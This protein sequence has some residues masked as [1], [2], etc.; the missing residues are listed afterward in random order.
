MSTTVGSQYYAVDFHIH[1]PASS[2]YKDKHATPDDI[3]QAALTAGLAA[4]AITDH[5][6]PLG[7]DKVRKAA[8]GTGLVIFP[9]VE[10]TSQG[11]HIIAVFDP[12]ASIDAVE[13][14]LIECGIGKGQWEKDNASAIGKDIL[15]VLSVIASKGGLAIA[16]HADGPKGFFTTILQG[17]THIRIYKDP[18][19]AAVELIS[20]DKKDLYVEGKVPGYD[21][22]VPCIQGS[23]AHSL[24]Q[25]G[26]ACVL[27]R[28]H[29]LSLEGVRQA[30]ADPKM[31]IRFPG[32]WKS[33]KYPFV[34]GLRVNQGF[35]TG[36]DLKF[37]PN[38]NC[39][40]GGAGSGKSTVIE[41]IRFALDQVSGIEHIARDCLGKLRDLAQLGASIE[42]IVELESGER[43]SI[44]RTFN[45]DDSPTVVRRISD[46]QLLD[47]VDIR[48]IFPVHAYS[49][50]EVISIS[51]NP[52]AQLELIDK[53]LE[54]HQFQ[55]DIKDAYRQLA[56]QSIGL[57]RLE[58]VVRDRETVEREAATIKTQVHDLTVELSRLL[59]AQKS[60]VVTSHQLW[61]AEKS[62]LAE[63]I[64]TGLR[65][66]SREIEEKLD[67]ID[68]HS[69]SIALPTENTPNR[70]LLEECRQTALQ[71]EEARKR[72]KLELLAVLKDAEE[73]IR[74]KA[75]V[76]KELHSKH[77]ADYQQYRTQQGET[78]IEPINAQLEKHRSRLHQ[79]Q[80]QSDSIDSAER[81]RTKLLTK[82]TD[83]LNL[84][85]DRRA[86]IFVLREHKAREIVK[87]IGDAIALRVVADGNR[88]QYELFVVELLKG[89][90]AP[91]EVARKICSSLLPDQLVPLL[92]R[93]DFQEID[94]QTQIGEKWAKALI[95]QAKGKPE[96]IYDLEV[97]PI[98]DRLDISFKI[99]SGN[100][101]EL[102]KLSTGQKAT[103]IV[104]LTMVEGKQP[105]IFDQPEDALYTPFIY[106]EVV[107]TLKGEKDQRQFILA[108]HNPNISVA[109]DMDLGIVLESTATHAT[110]KAVGGLDDRETQKLMILHLEG[111][112]DAFLTRKE[113][114]GL[115]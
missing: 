22:A 113:K 26:S 30:F 54:L 29:H 37:N 77:E 99:E 97:V 73:K 53:H 17:Q 21:R 65:S 91:R 3:V 67:D 112:E 35:L 98:E 27:I 49:Q 70:A 46:G 14:T 2:D 100:Y 61:I 104:L 93:E 32:E 4:I 58:A 103:V 41:F 5:N 1:T 45:D 44:T 28:M 13:E 85:R 105:I 69:L 74:E 7:V 115:K 56:D 111:G 78:R 50:G 89:R 96:S 90:Y 71:V 51:R 114:Y 48:K 23:D 66:A 79:L 82:R 33:V 95:E 110:V 75:Q 11:G 59:A 10:I 40:V 36:Q 52:L 84:V 16:A 60:P 39:I 62:Y 55:S 15:T 38:L 83:L 87:R 107:R 8:E 24:N 31:R 108:T 102:D 86:R 76:W 20:L 101:R 9:G 6:T 12:D 34:I 25:I 57:S 80:M 81:T 68:L 106:T 63:L 43:L 72:I 88:E 92:R 94:G 47:G 19:L 109:A 64:N 42:V 18:N